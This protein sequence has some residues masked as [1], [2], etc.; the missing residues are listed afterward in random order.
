MI[1]FISLDL[2]TYATR[3]INRIQQSFK[4]RPNWT[5]C[6]VKIKVERELEY[7]RS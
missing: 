3:A 4:L 5:E 1:L 2:K 6:G 7:G